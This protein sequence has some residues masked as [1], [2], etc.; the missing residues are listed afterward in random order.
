M[1]SLMAAG[2]RMVVE[3]FRVYSWPLSSLM[4]G[5]APAWPLSWRAVCMAGAQGG[6]RAGVSLVRPAFQIV[7]TTC[8][9]GLSHGGGQAYGLANRCDLSHS[10]SHQ[11]E[12][13]AS[14]NRL[15]QSQVLLYRR[16]AL[17]AAGAHVQAAGAPTQA[18][19]SFTAHGVDHSEA[20]LD[21]T[22]TQPSIKRSRFLV[23][24]GALELGPLTGL[25]GG[26]PYRRRPRP[27]DAAGGAPTHG[28]GGLMQA[29]DAAL[30]HS[31]G[32]GGALIH[33][34][35]TRPSIGTKRSFESRCP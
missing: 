8:R 27:R 5:G 4:A 31:R 29:A 2:A 15:D 6:W 30:D 22:R 17:Q 33:R 35:R 26:H 16:W 14:E 19:G 12:E 24:R 9:R 3:G 1:A 25:G 20:L 21:I 13:V 18:A 28:D 7:V 10:G 23:Y 32:R 11:T 34:R